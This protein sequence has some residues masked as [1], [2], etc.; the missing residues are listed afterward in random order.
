[1]HVFHTAGVPTRGELD[2]SQDWD[3]TLRALETPEKT[4]H[5]PEILYTH[6]QHPGQFSATHHRAKEKASTQVAKSQIAVLAS[7]LERNNLTEKFRIEE[8]SQIGRYRLV[9]V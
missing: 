4:A 2:G 8:T 5:I 9:P 1:M 6:R 3:I 7:Y